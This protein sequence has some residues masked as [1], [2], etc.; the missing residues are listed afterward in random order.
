MLLLEILTLGHIRLLYRQY[1]DI[2]E[3]HTTQMGCSVMSCAILFYSSLLRARGQKK[4]S[5]KMQFGSL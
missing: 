5:G 4:A 1:P 2:A 3:F